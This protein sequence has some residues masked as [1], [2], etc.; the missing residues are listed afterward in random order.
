MKLIVM[1]L[2]ALTQSGRFNPTA[3]SIRCDPQT[4]FYC[5]GGKCTS[6]PAATWGVLD[7]LA[8][9]YSRCDKNGC[10]AYPAQ[11]ERSGV[12][13]N[14]N[15]G[16]GLIAKIGDDGSFVEVA[17]LGTDVYVSQGRCR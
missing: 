7:N 15:P 12:F 14:I 2:V 5:S 16:R 8:K 6:V 1:A 17:T 11:I 10:D 9:T 4:K 3:P 13:T